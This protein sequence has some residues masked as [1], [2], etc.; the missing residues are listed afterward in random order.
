MVT[1][2]TT[3]SRSLASARMPVSHRK[4]RFSPKSGPALGGLSAL[5]ILLWTTLAT[6]ASPAS[7]S[8][9]GV[10]NASRPADVAEFA[11]SSA[12]DLPQL[13]SLVTQRSATVEE[14]RLNVAVASANTRQSHLL[15]NPVLD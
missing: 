5:P 13:E 14:A 7:P 10:G 11:P 6:A 15:K 12:T 1:S 9:S 4:G 3:R 2:C 8:P